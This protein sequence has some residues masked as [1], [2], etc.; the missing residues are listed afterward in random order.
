MNKYDLTGQKF[1]R[2]T[3]LE[4]DLN[5]RKEHNLKNQETYWKCQCEC[6]TIKTIVRGNLINGK[7]SS[8]GCLRREQMQSTS[9]IHIGERFGRL[10]VLERD[11]DFYKDKNPRKHK[12][13]FKCIC[14]CG[15]TIS[16]VSD[17]L[18]QGKTQSCGC[19]NS[20]GEQRIKQILNE[21]NV[22]FQVQ[23]T[24]ETCVSPQT[25]CK[26][27]FDF[28]INNSFL[29]E[30]DGIQHFQE[31]GW[32]SQED[33]L[34]IQTRDAFKNNWCKENHI[35]LKRIPYWKIDTLTLEDIMGDKYLIIW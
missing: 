14:D 29:L 8:C 2:W 30:F 6:G 31:G 25:R 12:S 27:R 23:K 4:R 22:M 33:F 26:Y 20:L 28:Y 10:I 3:V 15:N 9:E 7:S 17:S 34:G 18:R 35:P 32:N 21:N 13:V 1:G 5:Y 24:F 16:V 11:N 19:L